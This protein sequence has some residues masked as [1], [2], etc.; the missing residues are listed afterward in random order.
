MVSKIV[1]REELSDRTLEM[2]RRI[3]TV[4]TM[5]ALLTKESVNQS[6]GNM[7]CYNALQ[8]CI[9]LHQLNH[10][11][12]VGV[13]MTSVPPSARRRECRIGEPPPPDSPFG[14]RPSARR[15]E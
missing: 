10:S 15:G 14:Q 3:A 7:S 9:I 6:V 12:W 11:H 5:A 4:P 2:A 13:R 8:S 1:K